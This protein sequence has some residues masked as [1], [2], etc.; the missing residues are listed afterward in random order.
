MMEFLT[1]NTANEENQASFK[2]NSKTWEETRRVVDAYLKR[3]LS[4]NTHLA[5]NTLHPEGFYS[6]SFSEILKVF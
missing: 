1:S 4:Q 5:T 6:Y 3:S 2:N